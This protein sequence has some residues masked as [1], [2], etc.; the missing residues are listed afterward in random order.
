[1]AIE[2]RAVPN[3]IPSGVNTDVHMVPHLLGGRAMCRLL[4]T[5]GLTLKPHRFKTAS[6]SS[7]Q[8]GE[9]NETHSTSERTS[10]MVR[11][12][13]QHA[14]ITEI[15]PDNVY[16]IFTATVLLAAVRFT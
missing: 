1:M 3:K 7:V 10:Q 6:F 5:A 14:L 8:R 13:S 11:P 16:E 2:D 12:S 4:H 15:T 9:K